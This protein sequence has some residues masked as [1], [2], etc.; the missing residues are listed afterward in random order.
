MRFFP[1]YKERG[2]TPALNK[3]PHT[4]NKSS[5]WVVPTTEEMVT[6]SGHF[7]LRC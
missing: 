3:N 7:G 2:G 4:M 1:S 5:Y 6:A